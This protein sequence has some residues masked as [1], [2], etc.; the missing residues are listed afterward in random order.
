ME[1][2]A[3]NKADVTVTI[4]RHRPDGVDVIDF[5]HTRVQGVGQNRPQSTF[6]IQS[7]NTNKVQSHGLQPLTPGQQL[8]ACA[9][10]LLSLLLLT[11][12]FFVVADA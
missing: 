7:N 11:F 2:G 6:T 5:N 3:A 1:N 8:V 9:V 10:P 4:H 12:R